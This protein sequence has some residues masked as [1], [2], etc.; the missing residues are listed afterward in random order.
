MLELSCLVTRAMRDVETNQAVLWETAQQG[1][2]TAAKACTGRTCA[3]RAVVGEASLT[4]VPRQ[5]L[6][7]LKPERSNRRDGALWINQNKT[8][9]RLNIELIEK[10]ATAIARIN[11]R[12]RKILA[13]YSVH[14][15]VGNAVN[16]SDQHGGLWECASLDSQVAIDGPQRYG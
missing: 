12:P 3:H 7:V 11:A 1:R 4:R 10:L 9:A 5:R 16:L 6:R 15:V 8:P 13:L 14:D 2:G